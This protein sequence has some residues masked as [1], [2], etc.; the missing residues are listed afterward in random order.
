MLKTNSETT[1]SS[2]N[3]SKAMLAVN[4]PIEQ[5]S[6]LLSYYTNTQK[7]S[8][9]EIFDKSYSQAL[10]LMG[11]D[12]LLKP[13]GAI[14]SVIIRKTTTPGLYRLILNNPELTFK[15][16]YVD[17]SELVNNREYCR[18][19]VSKLDKD[20]YEITYFDDED[21]IVIEHFTKKEVIDF[22]S[23]NKL[24]FQN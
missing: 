18:G 5:D 9:E 3:D 15:V 21:E 20:S 8:E 10:E 16:R 17:E 22:M 19:S 7:N 2:T 23:K 6:T 4:N 24:I 13:S 14:S 11:G 1:N 12:R